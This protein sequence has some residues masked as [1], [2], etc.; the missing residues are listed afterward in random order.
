MPPDPRAVEP[1]RLPPSMRLLR[2]NRLR[3]ASTAAIALAGAA[4]LVAGVVTGSSLALGVPGLAAY[5]IGL[6]L[7]GR[8]VGRPAELEAD[9]RPLC[10]RDGALLAEGEPLIDRADVEHAF[11]ER[12]SGAEGALVRFRRKRRWGAGAS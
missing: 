1:V 4:A 9:P 12:R 3:V 11:V 2:P 5:A 7:L 6:I 8:A 10:A